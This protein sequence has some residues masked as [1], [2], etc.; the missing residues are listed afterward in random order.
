MGRG[1]W[2]MEGVRGGGHDHSGSGDWRG[3]FGGESVWVSNS[4][5][6]QRVVQIYRYMGK[7][8]PQVHLS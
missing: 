4:L 7:N 5:D 6:S 8:P 3:V 2:P 1:R